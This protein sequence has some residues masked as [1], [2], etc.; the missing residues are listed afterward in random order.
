MAKV[1]PRSRPAGASSQRPR[2]EDVAAAVGVSTA[3]V[4]LTLSDRPGPSE[5]TR[6]RVREAAERLGYRPDRTASLLARR[7]TRLLGVLLEIRNP[8]HAELIED[9]HLASEG[10][11]YDLVLSTVTASRDER[12]AIETLL[13]FRCEALILLGPSLS[14]GRL[15]ALAEQLPIVA[16]GKEPAAAGVDVVRGADDLGVGQ[17]VD[18]LVDLGHRRIAFVDGGKG[19]VASLRRRGYRTALRRHGLTDAL[20]IIPAD[21]NER[22]GAEAARALLAAAEPLPTALIAS[23]DHCAVG[24]QDELTRA[25]IRIPGDLSLIGYDNS[26]LA[27]LA[28]IDLTS[29]D[30]NAEKLAALAVE[31]ATD[32]LENGRGAPDEHVLTPHLVLRGTTA[33]PKPVSRASGTPGSA[34]R[35]SGRASGR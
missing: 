8:F 16:I 23:N 9:L 33:P 26:W 22:A 34:R 11:G 5:E 20:R 7:H 29:V 25:G 13:D 21:H 10:R 3:S 31:V 35:G 24:L 14:A 12:R 4:S 30:Q 15:S 28:H 17:A 1:D 18:H 27:R 19:S 32:R 6:R 2:L